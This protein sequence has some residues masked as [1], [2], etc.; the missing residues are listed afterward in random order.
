MLEFLSALLD[1]ISLV[2]TEAQKEGNSTWSQRHRKLIRGL[3]TFC[4]ISLCVAALVLLIQWLISLGPVGQK[5]AMGIGA[6]QLIGLLAF[7]DRR[8]K[9]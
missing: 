9:A 5:V 8:R 7:L 1:A 2:D 3:Y 6:I 4:L